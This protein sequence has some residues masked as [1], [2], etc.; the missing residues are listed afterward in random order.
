M[1]FCWSLSS[2]IFAISICDQPNPVNWP[3]AS[4][5][6][7]KPENH[8]LSVRSANQLGDTGF[9]GASLH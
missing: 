8:S 3:A 1:I 4:Y 6:Q 9:I 5:R 2:G 7:S